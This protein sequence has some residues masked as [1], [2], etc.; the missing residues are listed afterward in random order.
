MNLTKKDYRKLLNYYNI[1]YKKNIFYKKIKI[2]GEKI[3]SKKLCKC[4]KK[5]DK[6]NENK[7]IGIC[8]NAIFNYKGL[9]F[10]KFTCKKKQKI[11]GIKKTLKSLK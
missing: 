8:R 1:T 6:K 11:Y 10:K 4:I 9:T 7:S 5:V 2:L 3:L